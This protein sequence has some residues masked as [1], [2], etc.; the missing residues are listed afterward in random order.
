[1]KTLLLLVLLAVLLHPHSIS[2]A[3]ILAVEP[4]GSK[5]HWQYM[6]SILDV[7][8]THH[9]VTVITPLPIGDRE[10]YTE[11]DASS[12][13]PIYLEMNTIDLIEQFGSVIDLLPPMPERS[14][15]RDIC[16]AL[17][18]FGPV[19]DLLRADNDDKDG[20]YD[21]VLVE[22]F[23]SSCLS[24]LAYR[25]HVPEVYAIPFAIS[26]PTEIMFFGTESNPSYV[27]NLMFN[28]GVPKTFEQ[29]L[30]N[31]ALFVYVKFVTWL[32][33]TR[34]IYRDPKR[35][36]IPDVRH[37]PSMVFINTHTITEPPR[38]FPVNMIQIGGIHLKPPEILPYDI[39]EFIE[40]SPHG[41]IYFTFGSV[42]SMSTLPK[43]IQRTFI[44]TF[45]QVPQRI[46][47][48]YECEINDLPKN[49]MTRK[50]FPQRE[51]L[52][53]PNVKLFLSHGGISGVYE[54][55]D[56]GL[57][58]LG[59]P[60]FFDQ[61]RN[62]GNLVDAGMA[63]SMD[64]RTITKDSLLK[65]INELIKNKKYTSNAKLVSKFFKDRPLSPSESVK[66]SIDYVLRHHRSYY[67]HDEAHKSASWYQN[68]LLD[69]I[70]VVVILLS[71]FLYS[72]YLKFKILTKYIF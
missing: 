10:N 42:S 26:S 68:M 57:P 51:I 50:W 12:V 9:Q 33:D 40:N 19:A 67:L 1:M 60:L 25:L 29:R 54:A 2:G 41:I 38:P 31:L 22:P 14:H 71:I 47:W 8:T 61:P 43:H 17:Y 59:F 24:Y 39:L 20:H 7:L 58:I 6:R 56:A 45:A 13:L 27:P 62:V 16:D 3:R 36:D 11:I 64:I 32:T 46:L 23:H 15:E 63:L 49:I 37:K 34:M 28:G 30:T 35:Y 4:Y 44:D 5:S 66:Y 72:I 69:I 53:H 48:K 55:V 65:T 52:L 70:M 18:D 21:L